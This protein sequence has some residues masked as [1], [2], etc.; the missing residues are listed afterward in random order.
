VV[1]WRHATPGV[2]VLFVDLSFL[3]QFFSIQQKYSD[4]KHKHMAQGHMW[5]STP[6]DWHGIVL[7]HCGHQLLGHIDC[8]WQ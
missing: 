7:G 2:F 5:L 1:D 6:V 8:F 3:R 4:W